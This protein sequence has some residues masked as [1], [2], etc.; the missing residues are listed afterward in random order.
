MTGPEGSSAGVP[1]PSYAHKQFQGN[2]KKKDDEKGHTLTQLKG[3]PKRI[4]LSKP[5]FTKGP[6][7][8]SSLLTPHL[9]CPGRVGISTLA[10]GSSVMN[11]GYMNMDLVSWR[12]ACHVRES[13]CA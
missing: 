11:I 8:P 1:R 6:I 7:N 3:T 10:F 4:T 13:G 12:F 5:F 2:T 9:R